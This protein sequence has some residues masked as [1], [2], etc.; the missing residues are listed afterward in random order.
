[1]KF[2]MGQ[3]ISA[4]FGLA[5]LILSVV[6]V[7]SY[8][9]MTRFVQEAGWVEQSWRTL[10]ELDDV[11]DRLRAA[12]LRQRNYLLTGDESELELY[13]VAVGTI[14]QEIED[15]HRVT[16]DNLNHRQRLDTLEPLVAKAVAELKETIDLR[17]NSGATVAWQRALEGQS[18]QVINDISQVISEMEGEEKELLKTRQETRDATAQGMTFLVL[19][20]NFL[21]LMF[22]AV[23]G[24][25]VYRDF[26]ARNRTEEALRKSEERYRSLVETAKDVI[27]TVSVEGT[28]TSFNPAFETVTDWSRAEWLGKSFVPF[29][30]PDDASLALEIFH[31]LLQG[32]M[33]PLSELRVLFK[34]GKTRVWEFT[35][36]PQFQ[37][38]TVESVLVIAR[39]VTERKQVEAALRESETRFRAIFEGAAIGI[40]LADMQGRFVRSNPA[41]R[42]MVG[43]SEEELRGMPFTNF[44][45][46]DDTAIDWNLFQELAEGKR[47]Y[48]QR[49]ERCLRKDGGV[50]WIRLTVSFTRGA[51]GEPQFAVGMI[52][53]ISERKRAEE[54]LQESQERY[55]S[56]I[57]TAQDAFISIDTNGVITDWN[58]QAET[59][60][61]WSRAE[62]M[63]RPLAET[64]IPPQYREA[65]SYGLQ[66]FLT[67]GEG[68]VLNKRI[69][70]TA[71]HHDGHEF[72]VEVTIW[73][74]RRG[75]DYT[76]NAFVRDISERQAVER[77][78]DEFVS[79]VSHEL[80]TPLTSI[81]GALGLLTSGLV[82]T[83]PERGQRMLEIA[84][85]NTDRLVRLINDILDI[86]RIQSGQVTMQRQLCDA[87]PLLI[88]A[89]EEMQAMAEKAGVIL[90]MSSHSIPLW[91][92]P[93]RI[94][95][96]LTNLVSNAIKFSP[97]GGR[98]WLTVTRHGEEA[99]FAVK[100]QGRGIPSDKLES[101]FERFQQVDASDSRKKGGTGLGLAICRSIVQQHGGRIWVESAL[102]E[103][104]TFYFT[105][106]VWKEAE[107]GT[108]EPEGQP[109]VLACD[110]DPSVLEVV[111]TILEQRGYQ[112]VT[113]TSG[114]EAVKQ[115]AAQQPAVILLDLLMPQMNGWETMAALKNRGDT[116]DIP[117]IIFSIL[118]P[119][120]TKVSQPDFVD[121]VHKSSGEVALFQALRRALEERA[122]VARVLVVEDDR[123]LAKVLVAMFQRHG[124]ETVYA[125]TGREAVRVCE[126]LE[127]DLLVLDLILPDGDGFMVADWL[128]QH[129]RLRQMPLVVYSAKDLD[130]EERE[131]LQLGHTAFFTKGRITPEEFE[132][133]V[134]GLLD[135]IVPNKRGSLYGHNQAD[136]GH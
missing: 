116:R 75:V 4:G 130:G 11:P 1:M 69:E 110:D 89:T 71:T 15:L 129:D 83:L 3:K 30:H 85:N 8:R 117:I 63:R 114:Q 132:Q 96:T 61:G 90:S 109:L 36:A 92:D 33:P 46:P 45:H 18:K 133:R 73:P 108:P 128:K 42:E 66:R 54:V 76:F 86:E 22:V 13:R 28:F 34:S 81:R 9:A 104:S 100:D 99:V 93:D 106:P 112:V 44:T 127:P 37:G 40:A 136:S 58:H 123:D 102:G 84:V 118:P 52:E 23:A 115:A 47:D 21:A 65:H 103:G 39:D 135:R 121:W 125:H 57:E 56:I 119:Q 59:T 12:E 49:E 77:M 79:V 24:L 51:S 111:Q 101:V 38:E 48:Y 82:G 98:V 53:N 17:R 62:V 122:R 91:A 78:K 6:S 64:I 5:L 26:A 43:Y 95:Q 67:T 105:L 41:L 80:R 68:P 14:K 10:K 94:V 72:P 50:V 131:R 35:S 120:E 55:R 107:Q 87:A 74:V 29:V 60:F 88:Q 97:E 16:G 20:R 126:R 32:E 124:I 70:L 25:V 19:L 113:V 2:S 27:F 134:L 7:V 31:R